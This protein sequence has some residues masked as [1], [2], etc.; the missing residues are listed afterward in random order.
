M[1]NTQKK[2]KNKKQVG[3]NNPIRSSFEVM[4]LPSCKQSTL[5]PRNSR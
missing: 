3:G 4:Y 5:K 2:N 1:R